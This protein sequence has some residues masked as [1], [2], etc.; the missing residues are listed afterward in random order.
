MPDRDL[1]FTPAAE[2]LRLYRARKASPLE[3]M[4][5]VLA[6]IDAVNP[7]VNAIVTLA[8]DA[9]LWRRAPGHGRAQAEAPRCRRCSA[10][11]C[12]SRTSRRPR[13]SARPRARS[14]SRTTCPTRTRSSS[15]RLR[16][17]G[18]IVIGKT[19]TPEFAFGA[20]T[21]NAVFGATRN[22][23]NPTLH[24]RRLQRR[25]GGGAGHRHVPARRGHRP[26]RL[27]AQAR[28]RSA[29]WSASARRPAC[30]P[31][32]P[33]VLAWDTLLGRGP[34]GA[35]GRRHRADAVGDGRPRRP[36]AALLRRWTRASSAGGEGA[37]GQGLARRVDAGSRRPH[38]RRRRGARASSSSAVQ[39]LPLARRPRG[40]GV[41]GLQRRAGDRARSRA[42]C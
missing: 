2:L 8:R 25:R 29:A 13:A 23:W 24:R 42:A 20:N 6:R 12:P 10:C 9:A 18:A 39:R 15:Q 17:A 22:P 38:A 5:A 36:R 16:A 3:V 11:R 27:A 28:R 21:V 33:S 19:N 4:Q 40:G 14:S 32:Y 31:R 26:R 1:T 7:T 35:H 34:D 41:P 30:V 37:V